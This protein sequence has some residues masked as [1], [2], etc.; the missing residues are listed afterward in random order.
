MSEAEPARAGAPVLC[1]RELHKQFGAFVAVRG[2]SLSVHAGEIYGLIGPNGAGKSTTMRV[3]SSLLSPTSGRAEVAGC[4]VAREPMRAR[5]RLG[6]VSGTAGLYGRL[7]AREVLEFFGRLHLLDAEAIARRIDLLAEQLDLRE[8]LDRRCEK[9]S[10]GQKQRV[11]IARALVH[12]PPALILDEPTAGLD[13]LASDSLRKHV[14]AQ[15][16]AGCAILYTTHYLA[17]AELLCDRIGFIHRG[18][19]LREGT[20]A[21]LRA[22]TGTDSLERAF[23]ALVAREA[24]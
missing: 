23:L 9:L 17:E 18:R 21:A 13:V 3:L 7:T 8:L 10:T 15:R 1:A 2:L 11:S 20:S 22:E 5:S 6:F 16:A 12:E 19:L 4:D 24:A 14:L